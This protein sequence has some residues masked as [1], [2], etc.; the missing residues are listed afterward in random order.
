MQGPLKSGICV[1]VL[2]INH[3][4]M[5]PTRVVYFLIS[6]FRVVSRGTVFWM[7]LKQHCAIE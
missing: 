1:G 3:F 2:S 7:V 6:V 4:V 5:R